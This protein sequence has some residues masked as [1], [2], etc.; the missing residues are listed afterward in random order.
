VVALGDAP[1]AE[2]LLALGIDRNSNSIVK[3]MTVM[4]F[5]KSQMKLPELCHF[6]L[7]VFNVLQK[8]NAE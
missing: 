6:Y 1:L 5:V 4:A 7:S 3:G 2:W 8:Y